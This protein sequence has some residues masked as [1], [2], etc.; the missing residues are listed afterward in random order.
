MLVDLL[1]V[2]FYQFVIVLVKLEGKLS[3]ICGCVKLSSFE[4]VYGKIL[5]VE[6]F[7]FFLKKF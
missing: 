6:K 2:D 5:I 4:E 1:S 3:G 7:Y